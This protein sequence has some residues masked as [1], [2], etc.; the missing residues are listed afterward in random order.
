MLYDDR[1]KEEIYSISAESR[2][3][4]FMFYGKIVRWID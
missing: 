4:M 2:F 3:L 1:E